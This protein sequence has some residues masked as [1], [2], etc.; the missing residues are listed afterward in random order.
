MQRSDSMQDTAGSGAD[1]REYS[2]AALTRDMDSLVL[3]P[4]HVG[5]DEVAQRTAHNVAMLADPVQ[6]DAALAM[7]AHGPLDDVSHAGALAATF[8]IV[9]GKGPCQ[10]NVLMV[11]DYGLHVHYQ[12]PQLQSSDHR[13]CWT[14]MLY[15]RAFLQ[16]LD[17]HT[18]WPL[19]LAMCSFQTIGLARFGAAQRVELQTLMLPVVKQA[20]LRHGNDP[21]MVRIIVAV[22]YRCTLVQDCPLDSA[23]ERAVLAR[24]N[25]ESM[26]GALPEL[27]NAESFALQ[28]PHFIALHGDDDLI[29]KMVRQTLCN[30]QALHLNTAH[31][32]NLMAMAMHLGPVDSEEAMVRFF[33]SPVG[34]TA[35]LD[36]LRWW[37]C[38]TAL[39]N[40]EQQQRFMS[41]L[42]PHCLFLLGICCEN[43]FANTMQ[44][45]LKDCLTKTVRMCTEANPW[46]PHQC[47][48][49][50]WIHQLVREHTH[51]LLPRFQDHINFRQCCYAVLDLS[52]WKGPETDYDFM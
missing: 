23:E 14:T 41:V 48:S 35:L 18:V 22:L 38:Q 44:N 9:M 21:E 39:M 25:I 10:Y 34:A 3:T 27:P 32:D 47:R 2:E 8:G 37:S 24:Y 46:P 12:V 6:A 51:R 33:D 7:A 5:L 43:S 28:L 52:T 45:M 31:F 42:L 30:I 17:L 15:M 29:L 20:I 16:K 40:E 1:A 50:C 11:Y 19:E 49:Q 13:K 4:V 26:H 36:R